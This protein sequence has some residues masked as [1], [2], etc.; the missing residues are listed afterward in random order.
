MR[1]DA[2]DLRPAFCEYLQSNREQTPL[3]VHAAEGS[4]SFEVIQFLLESGADATL[5]DDD[6]RAP[7]EISKSRQ[8]S[9]VVELFEIWSD[10]SDS[11]FD[12][13]D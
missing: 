9:D 7:V 3:H 2:H 1:L 4:K 8:D 13:D 6:D 10:D 11:D 12:F 5:T